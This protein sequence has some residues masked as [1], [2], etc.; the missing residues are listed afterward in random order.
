[1][2]VGVQL[3]GA[4]GLQDAPLGER[5]A[6]ELQADRAAIG[7]KPARHADRRQAEVVERP[8][9]GGDRHEP[10]FGSG[11]AVVDV[12]LRQGGQ[13]G[14]DGGGDQDVGLGEHLVGELLQERAAAAKRFDVV[15]GG[16]GVAGIHP[17]A[18]MR[19]V[20]LR[21]RPHPLGMDRCGFGSGD[22]AAIRGD[23]V[24]QR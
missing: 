10:V 5:A 9:V 8:G 15:G 21:V 3:V 6:G 7:V 23:G 22:D 1:M 16:N 18:D 24:H 19:A 12:G 17:P 11:R 2:P 4:G 14:A 20:G 13:A